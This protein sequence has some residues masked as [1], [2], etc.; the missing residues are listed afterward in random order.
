MSELFNNEIIPENAILIGLITPNQDEERVKEYLDELAFLVDTAGAIPIKR[1]VQR[2]AMPDSKTFVGSGKLIEISQFV[3]SNSDV[4]VVWGG[5]HASLLPLQ[6]INNKYIDIVV[7]GEGDYTLLELVK[8]LKNKK[9]LK[10]VDGIYFKEKSGKIKKNNPRKAIENLDDLPPMPYD[11]INLKKY[12]GMDLEGKPS[13][14]LMTSRGCPFR[15]AFCYN[16]V[17]HQRKWRGKSA[18]KVLDDISYV[19]EKLKINN[20]Y[21]E[22]DNFCADLNRFN[23]IVDGIISNKFDIKWG[24]LGVRI[25]SLKVMS[26]DFLKKV[27]KAGC[28]NIDVGIESGN[29]RVLKLIQKDITVPQIIESNRKLSG[30][31]F[32]TKYTFIGGFPTETENELKQSVRL[33]L[34]LTKENKNAYTPFFIYTV[35]PGT[36]LYSLCLKNGFKPPEYLGG[37]ATLDYDNSYLHYPWLSKRRIKILRNLTFTSNFANKNIKYK[38]QKKYLKVL[39]DLYHPLAKFRF[40]HNFYYLPIERLLMDKITK[41]V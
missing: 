28:V 40:K 33:S 18:E 17:F 22:D 41:N 10:K 19:I 26:N 5:V 7:Y 9:D 4:P 16:T 15:C 32:I 12:Y 30:F 20:I 25:N 3:K 36:A 38:I 6:T 31:S 13:I 35:Y 8:E 34:K 14:T 21:F 1:F 24:L 2:L 37:W 29:D 23:K 39:F 11:L 27:S